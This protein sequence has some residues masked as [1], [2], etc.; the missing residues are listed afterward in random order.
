LAQRRFRYLT[1]EHLWPLIAI[2]GVFVV[3]A[4]YPIRPHDFWW[5]LRVGQEIA[6]SGS[7]PEIDTFSYTMTGAPYESYASY[8]LVEV[9]YHFLYGLGALPLVIAAHAV[10]VT[11]AYV[12]VLWL[13]TRSSGSVRLGSVGALYAAAL[14]FDNW[15]VRPQAVAYLFFAVCL[16]AILSYRER[17]RRWL[18]VL[19]PL[20]IALWVNCHGSFVLGLALL[21]IWLA[22]SIWAALRQVT[23]T[24]VSGGP[25]V[26]TDMASVG[27][28]AIL[29]LVSVVASLLNPRG[30]QVFSYVATI[31]RN[32]VIR[33]LVVEW[34]PPTLDTLGGA[35]FIVALLLV[36][37]LFLVSPRRPDPFTL[38]A[39]TGFAFLGLHSLRSI[40][41]FGL[42]LAPSVSAQLASTWTGWR[43]LRT[44]AANPSRPPGALSCVLNHLIAVIVLAGAIGSLPWL[45]HTLPLPPRKAGLVSLETPVEAVNILLDQRPP[46][47]IFNELGFGSY[48]IWAAREYP[49]Y[50]DTRIE[51]YPVSQWTE[52]VSVSAAEPG[53]EERLAARGVNTL[54]L[55]PE[56]QPALVQAAGRSP[57]WRIIW[58]DA[59]AV[60]LTRTEQP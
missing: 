32:V 33:S 52:Y 26:R 23:R 36:T 44:R 15:N 53:W 31:S 10:V 43:L 45:K 60:L 58:G 11:A 51:L 8:W 48:L 1:V 6:A 2:A 3:V 27:I 12:I 41:W 57:D 59:N 7:I 18:L 50:I 19:P 14:G 9:V 49:V 17:P 34:Q 21:G 5:H 37:V 47:Q 30:P 39:Y 40:I 38:L 20:A 24:R 22:D 42:V 35:V 4:T 46:R 54:L 13:S 25:A 28:S 29:L 16:F 55:N 56:T